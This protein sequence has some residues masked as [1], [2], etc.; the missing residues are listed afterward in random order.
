LQSGVAIVASAIDGIPEDVTDERSALLV[1]A[2]AAAALALALRRLLT[3]AALRRRLAGAGRAV[4]Q[5]RFSAEALAA[6]LRTVYA[7]LGVSPA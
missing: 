5:E 2:G 6:G 1:P 3:D 7:E 4:F